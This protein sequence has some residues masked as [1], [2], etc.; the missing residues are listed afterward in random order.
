MP[1]Y[2]RDKKRGFRKLKIEK[3]EEFDSL[4]ELSRL[5]EL[6]GAM[7][8]WKFPAPPRPDDF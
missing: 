6:L 4:D 8:V 1:V 7:V 3:L 2:A 5:S